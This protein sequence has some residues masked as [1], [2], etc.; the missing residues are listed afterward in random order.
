MAEEPRRRQTIDPT[1]A[2]ILDSQQRRQ[3]ETHLS[4]KERKKKVR[5]R[6][7]IQERRQK[8]VTYDLPPAIRQQITDTATKHSVPASQIAALLLQH[9][10]GALDRG[11]IDLDAHK[12]PSKSPR[13]DWNLVIKSED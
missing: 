5:E 3:A 7:K 6:E 11:E 13:Y 10:L 4:P 12:K 2:D 1:V 9:G 8:R